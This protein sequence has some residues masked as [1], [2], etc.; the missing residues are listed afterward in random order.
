M[1]TDPTSVQVTSSTLKG[2]LLAQLV[3][4]WTQLDYRG[5]RSNSLAFACVVAYPS[6][7]SRGSS[8][9]QLICVSH[10]I[11]HQQCVCY[12]YCGPATCHM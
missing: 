4:M 3:P 6:A 7:V 8:H 11:S 12:K 2:S 9:Q 1:A 5:W 10:N